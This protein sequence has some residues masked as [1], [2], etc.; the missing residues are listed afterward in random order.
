MDSTS[1]AINE[2]FNALQ[3]CP[4]A[5]SSSHIAEMIPAVDRAV[6][7]STADGEDRCNRSDAFRPPA[8]RRPEQFDNNPYQVFIY[9]YLSPVLVALTVVTNGLV[10]VVLLKKTMRNPTNTLLVAMAISDTLT[11][12]LP[13]PAFVRF[14]TSGRYQDWIP[15]EWCFAYAALADYLPTICHT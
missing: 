8:D 9:G 12:L 15:A 3:T 10:C 7:N 1:V 14:Y 4:A 2:E 13:I 11:G 6:C 5:V